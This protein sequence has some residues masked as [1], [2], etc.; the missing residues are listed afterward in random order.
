MPYNN[1]MNRDIAR[2]LNT[3]NE[4]FATLYAYS[5]VDGRGGYEGGA[6][7]VLFQTASASKRDGEDNM[8]NNQMNLPNVYHY[9]NDSEGMDGGNAFAKGTFRD[10]GFG[11]SLGA[12]KATGEFDKDN[13]VGYG[14]GVVGA[15]M[16][17]G[18]FWDTLGDIGNTALKFAP[19]LLALGKPT[20]GSHAEDIGKAFK[21]TMEGAGISGGNF[22]NDFIKGIGDVADVAGK[23]VPVAMKV[24]GKGDVGEAQITP[25]GG[26]K[27]GRPKKCEG[28]GLKED[29]KKATKFGADIITEMKTNPTEAKKKLEKIANT[30][31]GDIISMTKKGGAI[32]G[33]PDGYP[34]Q[35]NSQRVAGRGRPKVSGKNGDLLAMASPDLANGTPP[36]AQLRGS[37]GGVKPTKEEK[38][39]IRDVKKMMG[40]G[41]KILPGA[42]RMEASGVSGGKGGR[43]KRA[44]IVK[45]IMKER[46]VKMIEASK[47]VKKEGLYKP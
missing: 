4:R 8:Y 9:G 40:K 19:L 17:G 37:Y 46:G 34:R 22:W 28:S 36:T 6:A 25:S 29:I 41:E 13:I 15:G 2:Q 43:S 32:L 21:E 45:K 14:N 20:G 12:G 31:V 44:E 23:I 33:N 7:G 1:E 38:K 35:G 16:E 27:R 39:M 26:K 10:T 5:P 42:C 47:I 3:I 24:F 30:S 18:T 11:E